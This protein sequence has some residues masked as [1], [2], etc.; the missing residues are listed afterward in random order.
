M[1]L[2]ELVQE[3]S[4]GFN[5][6]S[7]SYSRLYSS[8]YGSAGGSSLGSAGRELD[9]GMRISDRSTRNTLFL[10]QDLSEGFRLGYSYHDGGYGRCELSLKGYGKLSDIFRGE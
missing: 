6:E 10:V 8:S 4:Q 7:Y 2:T 1:S 9:G 5:L 3:E